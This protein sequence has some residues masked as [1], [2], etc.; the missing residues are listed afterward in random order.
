M[1]TPKWNENRVKN[2]IISLLRSGSRKWPPRSN[3]L[4]AAKTEKKIN[5][6]SKRLAQHYKC[7]ACKKD[8]PLTQI[9]VDHIEPVVDPATGFI[10]WNTY[11]QRMF[12]DEAFLQVLCDGCHTKKTNKERKQRKCK[13]Q[14]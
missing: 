1:A 12:V 3:V 2:F 4:N 11:I 6:K 13:S 10:D 9:S 8:F 14:K 5:P 7:N